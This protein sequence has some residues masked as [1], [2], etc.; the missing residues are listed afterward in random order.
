MENWKWP[1]NI[2]SPLWL[3]SQG[4]PYVST[5]TPFGL[6]EMHASSLIDHNWLSWRFG[7]MNQI[8]NQGDT[9][10]IQN[11]SLLIIA[12]DD[13]HVWQFTSNGNYSV[14][15]SYHHIME[16]MLSNDIYKVEGDW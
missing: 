5:T 9:Q 12:D 4:N 11:M 6:E 7:I 14:R 8:L 1:V 10:V 3:R 15:S 2:W 13:T 16:S